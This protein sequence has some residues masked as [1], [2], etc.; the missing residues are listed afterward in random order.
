[1]SNQYYYNN[2]TVLM[3]MCDFLLSSPLRGI[4]NLFTPY[5]CSLTLVQVVPVV[6]TAGIESIF[7]VRSDFLLPTN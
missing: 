1:M 5:D 4:V 7:K 2:L 6:R 3:C